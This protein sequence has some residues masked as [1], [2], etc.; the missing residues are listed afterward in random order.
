MYFE[1]LGIFVPEAPPSEPGPNGLL[2]VV[3]SLVTFEAAL[4]CDGAGAVVAERA[5]A[6]R[7]VGSA[8]RVQLR[9]AADA[10]DG[11]GGILVR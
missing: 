11:T 1:K 2:Y 7:E 5:G 9:T 8:C 4:L 3:G 6:S 10:E